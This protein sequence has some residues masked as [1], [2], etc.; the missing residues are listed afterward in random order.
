MQ[1]QQ[2][3]YTLKTINSV[4]LD[5]FK[6]YFDNLPVDPYLKENY[7]FRRLSHFKVTSTGLIK[8]PHN[9]FF[10][11][12]EYNPLLGDIIREYP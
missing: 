11:S 6:S 5:R 7:R 9:R 2:A 10:Q 8:L 3:D 1:K 12:K 4:K